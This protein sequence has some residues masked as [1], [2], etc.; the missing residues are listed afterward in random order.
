[1]SGSPQRWM[2][3]AQHMPLLTRACLP[4]LALADANC[5]GSS[6]RGNYSLAAAEGLSW[7]CLYCITVLSPRVPRWPTA[8]G[9]SAELDCRWRKDSFCY[10]LKPLCQDCPISSSKYVLL[11]VTDVLMGFSVTCP[12]PGILPFQLLSSA[13]HFLQSLGLVL[14]DR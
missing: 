12:D 6:L 2:P 1:M 10:I 13:P 4:R 14:G 8:W 5:S 9:V 11:Q 3:W 7:N